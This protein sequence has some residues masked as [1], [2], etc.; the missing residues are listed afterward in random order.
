VIDCVID[1]GNE[2]MIIDYKTDRIR[3]PDD[4]GRL[5]ERYSAQIDAYRRA[6]ATIWRTRV[7]LSY[8]YFL[9]AGEAVAVEDPLG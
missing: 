2:A 6:L 9:D 7:S 3:N 4:L 5:K 1:A 8:L